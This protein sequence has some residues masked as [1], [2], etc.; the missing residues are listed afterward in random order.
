MDLYNLIDHYGRQPGN[1]IHI[2]LDYQQ[3]KDQNYIS[4]DD[5][6][7]IAREMKI[8]ESRIYSVMTFYSLF[9]TKPRGKFI[10]QVCSDIPCHVNGAADI[11]RTLENSL[12]IRMGETTPDGIFTLEYT[13]CIGCCDKSPAIRIGSEIFGNLTA[14]GLSGIISEYRRKYHESRE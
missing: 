6:R 4:E 8:P 10:I 13:S 11:V 2:L 7:L 1:L 14:S 3:S 5:V 9:S 12:L